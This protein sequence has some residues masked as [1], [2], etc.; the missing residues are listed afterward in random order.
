MAS[1]MPI[2]IPCPRAPAAPRRAVPHPVGRPLPR[3]GLRGAA[4]AGLAAT[5]TAKAARSAPEKFPEAVEVEVSLGPDGTKVRVLE[6]SLDWQE[7]LIEEAVERFDDNPLDADPYGMAVW[8]AGQVLAQAAS[9]Y[10]LEARQK[11]KPL[12]ALELGCGCGLASLTL[13]SLQCSVIASDFQQLPLQLLQEAA[14]RQG[15]EKR[16]KVQKFDLCDAS[17]RLPEADLVMASDVLYERQT[18]EA[19]ARRVDEALERGSRVLVADI[20]RPNR[21][22]FL[23]TLQDLRPEED[24]SFSCSATAV[25]VGS[26]TSSTSATTSETTVELLELPQHGPAEAALRTWPNTELRRPEKHGHVL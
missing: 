18:A 16:L 2:V 5:A 26:T 7:A 23:S 3:R 11:G 14:R 24:F 17:A 10:G 12:T 25:H 8:P 9:A 13:L 4:F 6:A 21:K 1:L 15:F 19:M 22:V 20:G